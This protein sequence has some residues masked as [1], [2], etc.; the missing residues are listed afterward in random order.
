MRLILPLLVPAPAD[1]APR[2][3]KGTVVVGSKA[4]P[5]ACLP[6]SGRI[7]GP[8]ALEP[9]LELG[10]RAPRG[11]RANR[12]TERLARRMLGIV[13]RPAADDD[14]F[15]RERSVTERPDG[16]THAVYERTDG[17]EVRV[18][19][20]QEGGAVIE[21]RD[22]HGAGHTLGLE[23][24]EVVPDCPRA[25]GDVPATWDHTYTFGKA[26]AKHGKRT[27]TLVRLRVEATWTGHVGAGAKAET[28]DFTLRGEVSVR[29]GVEIAATGKALERMPTRTYRSALTKRDVKVGTDAMRF[30]KELTLRGPKGA[31]ATAEDIQPATGLLTASVMAVN[32][33]SDALE[34]GDR[35]WYEQRACATLDFSSTPERVVKGGR[36]DWDVRVLA[37]DGTPAADARW[38]PASGCGELTASATSGP[39][40]T[41]AVTDA[42][43]AWGP[44]PYA[45]AC[46]TAE[47]T[48]T[49]GRPRA[50]D[51]SIP[52]EEAK[53]R[54]YA[55]SVMFNKSMGPG[56]AETDATGTGTVTAGPG[57]GLVIGTGSFGGT[58][59][60]AT[61]TNTCGQ[62]MARTRPF[63]SPATVGAEVESDEVTIAFTADLR[64]LDAAWIVTLP[65]AGGERTFTSRQPFC[66]TPGLALTTATIRVA[67][68]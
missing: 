48:S 60:D 51:H 19:A 68:S 10:L 25:N 30:A 63:S 29:S 15:G 13:A 56:I 28:F 4:K 16:S 43:G 47:V 58:E 38:A 8:Q 2:C 62:D 36:A 17:I 46:A 49:A 33:M 34:R 24:A 31:R 7:A 37:S 44:N 20:R 57:D 3:P 61:V 59:W 12:R 66:G 22:R 11:A 26:V 50:F 45:G 40:I 5:R 65:I 23:R 41:L 67:A 1:A 6:K 27:W 52:P 55:I 35:R 42:R 39:A 9:L 32:D 53:R 14:L 64:P 21:L 18:D 54:R